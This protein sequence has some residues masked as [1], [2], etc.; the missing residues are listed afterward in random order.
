[1]PL[2][3]PSERLGH[4][5]VVVTASNMRTLGKQ[6]ARDHTQALEGVFPV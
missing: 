1:M 4:S 6:A 2:A 3:V 5:S